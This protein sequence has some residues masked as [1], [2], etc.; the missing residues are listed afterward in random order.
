ADRAS[1]LDGLDRVAAGGT[2][3][4]VVRGTAFGDPGRTVFVFP[5][6]GS[7]WPGM[8]VE[9]LE[10]SPVFA[11]RLTEC[12]AALRPFVDWD[13]LDVLRGAPGA[14]SLD[15][16]DVVQPALW[17][18]MVALAE[19]WRA[20]GIVPDA[21]VGHSQ[22]EIAAACVAGA[23]SLPDGAKVVA[24]RSRAIREDLAGQGGMMSVALPAGEAARSLAR[25]DGRLQ[26]AVVNSPRS[27]VVCGAPDALAEL[28]VRLEADNVQ[29]RTIPVDYASH[30]VYVEG[31]RD[32]LLTDLAG[33]TPKTPEIA[34][35][36]TV[37]GKAHTAALD[38][39]YWYT[40]L[41]QTV[42]FEDA[43]RA[44]L[45]DG[46]GVF[47]EASPHPG[48]LV[49]LDETVTEAGATAVLVGTLRRGEGGMAQVVT[50]LAEAYV[51]GAA[52]AWPAL[53]TGARRVDLP[54]YAFQ[55]QRY[56]RD[57]PQAPGDA[58]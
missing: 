8:G 22:G 2:A 7:Q 10:S 14:P 27:V 49:G 53:F 38:A 57:V 3:E 42:R 47:V 54:T 55:R 6:Q 20:A 34:F 16:V 36:S 13:L 37:T 48:L 24:L 50:S 28:R 44:L 12:A 43:A 5:G 9:L 18:I 30:S 58:A 1:L 17:A 21:V 29:T 33:I 23:L 35:F 52:V 56:W 25:W 19:V 32:R 45:D 4:T 31:L 11:A 51:R 41:R 39:E 40:N 15:A 26:I 46:Y